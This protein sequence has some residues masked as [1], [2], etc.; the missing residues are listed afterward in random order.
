MFIYVK[1]SKDLIRSYLQAGIRI[2]S[3][4]DRIR[5]RIQRPRTS[6]IQIRIQ[7]LRVIRIRSQPLR[8]N[9]IQPL[10]T[11]WIRIQ[12]KHRIRNPAYRVS[13]PK[14]IVRSAGMN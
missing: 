12:T 1:H 14:T 7:P 11:N 4:I 8:T 6:R 5:I 10:R 2:R 3:D 13:H 9:R